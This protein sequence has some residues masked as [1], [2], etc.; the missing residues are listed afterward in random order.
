MSLRKL[1]ICGFRYYLEYQIKCGAPEAEQKWRYLHSLKVH[2]S[3]LMSRQNNGKET[4]QILQPPTGLKSLLLWDYPGVSLPSWF[5]PQKLPNL[6]SLASI[7]IFSS[8][9]DLSIYCC[10]DLSSLEYF[11]HP[12]SVPAIKKITIKKCERLLSYQL[13]DS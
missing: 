7:G 11:L 4:P 1:E 9:T 5:Q 3:S 6:I 8:L 2:R 10:Q 13:K 12:A